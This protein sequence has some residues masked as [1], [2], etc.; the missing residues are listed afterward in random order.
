MV[1]FLV[2]HVSSY[3]IRMKAVIILIRGSNGRDTSAEDSV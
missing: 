1:I 2:S 3:K